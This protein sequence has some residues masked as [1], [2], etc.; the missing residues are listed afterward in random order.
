MENQN[1]NKTIEFLKDQYEKSEYY[2]S[3]KIDKD[4]RLEHTLRVTN[5]GI[6]IAKK[7]NLDVEALALGCILHDVSYMNNFNSEEDWLN[8]GRSSAQIARPYLEALGLAQGKIDEICYGIAIHVDDKADFEGERTPLA[9]SIGDADNID[10]FDSYRV[11]E[12]LQHVKFNEKELHE[13]IEYV[14]RNL[15]KLNKYMNMELGTGTAK[16]MWKDKIGFQILF[17]RRL[18]KQLK[19]GSHVSME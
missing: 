12:T 5:I 17:F 16:I 6:E 7:E 9:I 3:N 11:Y 1:I 14:E 18:E 2:K 13:K 15:E 8:H 19:N 10:R 4:Y